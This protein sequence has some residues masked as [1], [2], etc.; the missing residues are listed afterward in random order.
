MLL[1]HLF[2]NRINISE[3]GNIFKGDLATQRINQA[4]VAPTVAWLEK[5][6]GL[7]LQDGMLGTTGRKDTS[8]DL[9]L[10]VDSRSISKDQLVAKLSAVAKAMNLNPADVIKKSG[11]SVHFRTPIAGDPKKGHVQADFMFTD[12]PE[13]TKFSMAASGTSQYK[14]AHKH[15][16]MS[17]IAKAMGLKWSATAGLL[18]R[19]SGKLLSKNPDE[20]AEM[21]L[22]KGR[23]RK[24]LESVE[25]LLDALKDDPERDE[26]LLDARETLARENVKLP[27]SIN[28]A[29][30][31]YDRDHYG[32]WT[33]DMSQKP[34]KMPKLTGDTVMYVAK[35]THKKIEGLVL[36]GKGNTQGAARD[37]AM[38]QIHDK[39]R[40]ADPDAF[41]QFTIDLN[42]DF[43]REYL[44]PKSGNYFKMA[45]NDA[46]EPVL[47]M[48]SRD[49]F[50]AFGKDMEQLGFRRGYQ[51]TSAARMGAAATPVYAVPTSKGQVKALGLIPN[52]RY[53]LHDVG[54]DEDGNQMFAL[55]ADTRV[56]SPQDR[57]KMGVPGLTLAATMAEDAPADQVHG[58]DKAA[59]SSVS[60]AICKSVCC[61]LS[62]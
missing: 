44:D 39:T 19:D 54:Q 56:I 10:A 16:V 40:S 8:G 41:K 43:T 50:A 15:I 23:D 38:S 53:S 28:E 46:G 2:E 37:D 47:V 49:Y 60:K 51:R 13:W 14:G 48:A 3:G 42:V 57:Y 29:V 5:H 31:G 1:T 52:M 33:V 36:Y 22:G 58:T 25:T 61:F 12:D 18:T 21:L 20:I 59:C 11:I 32:N 9:D 34:V 7:P 6:T 35:A 27:E 26:K 24:D 17:S 4:D 30:P 55:K 45:K 62:S